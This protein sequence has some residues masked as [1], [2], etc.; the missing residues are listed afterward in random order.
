VSVNKIFLNSDI[1]QCASE[2]IFK[3]GQHLAKTWTKVRWHVFC[4]N[5]YFY[6]VKLRVARYCQSK[7]SVRPSVCDIEVSWSYRLEFLE[8]N[9]TAD[10]PNLFALCM[11]D[12]LQREHPQILAGIGEG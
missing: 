11:T 6:R 12:L 3:S 10:K 1:S 9:F 5:V 7:L 2:N 4:R 8:N